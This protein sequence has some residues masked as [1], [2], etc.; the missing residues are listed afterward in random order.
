[1]RGVLPL[2]V[3]TLLLASTATPPPLEWRKIRETHGINVYRSKVPGTAIVAFKGDGRVDVPILRVAHVIID[4]SRG[5]EWVGSLAESRNI[6]PISELEFVEYDHFNMPFIIQ[7]RDF[8]SRVTVETDPVAK[9]VRVQFIATE[10]P[11]MPPT[12]RYVRGALIYSSFLLRAE[13]PD[14]TMVEAEILCDPKGSVPKWLVN[15]FQRSW[16]IATLSALRRQSARPDV[17]PHPVL[18]R[19]WAQATAAAT[20]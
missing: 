4:P 13:G 1:M 6:R 2:I 7:D 20:R 19:I 5:P 17:G 10:D 8:V 15:F 9:T 3:V 16:P 18:Q 11:T 14:T 12:A